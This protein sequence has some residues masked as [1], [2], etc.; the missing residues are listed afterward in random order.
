M[1]LIMPVLLMVI[2]I[3]HI[4]F[5]VLEMF[6]W[7][8]LFGKKLFHMSDEFAANSQALA[9]NQGLYNGFL[10]A[11]C[12]WAALSGSFSVTLFFLICVFLAGVFGAITV[13][14]KIF[15]LQGFPAMLALVLLFQL[16]YS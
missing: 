12:V 9:A 16:P 5:M 7:N 13:N 3:L 4:G 8:K 11:G 2:A 1:S 15:W 14:R 6:L 10:A